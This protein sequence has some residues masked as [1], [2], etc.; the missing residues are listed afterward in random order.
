M[1]AGGLEQLRVA[2]ER[3]LD[4]VGDLEARRFARVL[5]RVDDLAGQA[6][7]AQLVVELELQGDGVA[8]LGLDLVA[9]E[10]LQGE[11]QLVGAERVLV[12]V[13]VDPDLAA[14][15]PSPRRRGPGRAPRPRPRPA[16]SA[17]RSAARAR[18]SSA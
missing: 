14:R 7:A 1:V 12:A 8:G 2:A 3:E 15:R 16:A 17:C 9:L 10:R 18:G 11:G 4:P 5:D 6:L 13:D